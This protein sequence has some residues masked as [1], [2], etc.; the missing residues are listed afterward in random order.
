MP[1]GRVYIKCQQN[2]AQSNLSSFLL[3]L[4]LN[5][6]AAL[7]APPLPV[8]PFILSHLTS[9]GVMVT[10]KPARRGM[11]RVLWTVYA[12]TSIAYRPSLPAPALAVLSR[13]LTAPSGLSSLENPMPTLC[14]ALTTAPLTY[15]VTL[16]TCSA[17]SK[18]MAAK[19]MLKSTTPMAR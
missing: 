6:P 17:P 3:I 1:T 7:V 15:E 4:C 18:L 9:F 16:P 5:C 11:K 14:T 19:E 13:P 8:H 10:V 12:S 2:P